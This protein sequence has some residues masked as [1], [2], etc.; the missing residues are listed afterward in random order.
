MSARSTWLQGPERELQGA[1]EWWAKR[2]SKFPGNLA[3]C[4]FVLRRREF[5]GFW[6]DLTGVQPVSEG[7]RQV[8]REFQGDLFGF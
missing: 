7:I 1:R 8:S 4:L 3:V 2:R 6:G 5:A